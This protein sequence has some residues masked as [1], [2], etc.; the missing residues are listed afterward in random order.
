MK[1]GT[2][3]AREGGLAFSLTSAPSRQGKELGQGTAQSWDG[4]DYGKFAWQASKGPETW[5]DLTADCQWC[6]CRRL[7]SL[8]SAKLAS[9]RP[10]RTLTSTTGTTLSGLSNTGAY[11]PEQSN[12]L[13]TS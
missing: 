3:I 11:I 13:I 7:G 6:W 5:Q 10:N 2:I 4:W 9:G 8:G 1:E 12:F